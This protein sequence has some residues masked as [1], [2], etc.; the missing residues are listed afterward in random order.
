M[1]VVWDSEGVDSLTLGKSL[2]SESLSSF[3]TWVC[4]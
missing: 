4:H 2:L 3:V 1:A